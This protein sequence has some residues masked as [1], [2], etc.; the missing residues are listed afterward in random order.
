MST[1]I[2]FRHSNNNNSLNSNSINSSPNG[3]NNHNHTQN[4]G[5]TQRLNTTSHL[6]QAQSDSNLD[7]SPSIIISNKGRQ[8]SKHLIFFS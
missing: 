8:Q 5:L 4:N 7:S 6:N 1:Q 2:T 3:N